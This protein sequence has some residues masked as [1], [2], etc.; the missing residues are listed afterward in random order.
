M[1]S[2]GEDDNVNPPHTSLKKRRVQRAC[3]V[4]RRRKIRCDGNRTPGSRCTTCS[5]NDLECT[6]LEAERTRR[7]SK[8]YVESLESRLDQMERLLSKLCPDGNVSERLLQEASSGDTRTPSDVARSIASVPTAQTLYGAATF[9]SEAETATPEDPV[10][11]D[12]DVDVLDLKLT[13]SVRSMAI[14]PIR[15]RFFGKSSGLKLIQQALD[16]KNEHTG[17]QAENMFDIFYRKRSPF[18]GISPVSTSIPFPLG[19]VAMPSFDRAAFIDVFYNKWQAPSEIKMPSYTFP[20]HDLCCKLIDLYF[21]HTNTIA[22]LLHRPTFERKYADGL[23]LRDSTFGAV[24]L[25]VCAVASTECDD[26]RVLLTGMGTE[27]SAGWKYFQQVQTMSQVFL[28]APCLEDMQMCCLS[29]TFLQGTWA[30]QACWTIVGIGIRLAQDVGAHRRKVYNRKPTVEDELWKR[31]FWIMVILDRGLSTGLGRPC[32]M[33]DTDFDLD[34]PIVCDDEYWEH[35][36]PEQAFKQPPGNPSY[37]AYFVSAIKLSQVLAFALRTIYSINKSKVRFGF[38]GH[39]WEQHIVAELDSALNK[40]IDTVP[41]HL[42]WSP[43]IQKP[44]FLLQSCTLYTSY[45][46]TQILIH[47]PFIPSPR[48]PSPLSYPS[49]AIC[50]NAARLCSHVIDEYVQRMGTDMTPLPV[51][52]QTAAIMAGIILLVSIWGNKKSGLAVN[53]EKDMADVHKCMDAIKLGES[54]YPF[55]GRFWDLLYELASVGDLPLPQSKPARAGKREREDGGSSAASVPHAGQPETGPRIIAGSSR[56]AA[57][58]NQA[59]PT[60][61]PHM[62]AQPQQSPQLPMP[63][64]TG[65][66]MAT[67]FSVPWQPP[68]ALNWGD[69]DPYGTWLGVG[70]GGL[71]PSTLMMDHDGLSPGDAGDS[72]STHA[73]VSGVGASTSANAAPH[74]PYGMDD[75]L[76]HLMQSQQQEQTGA[77]AEAFSTTEFEHMGTGR[78]MP[79]NP[80]SSGNGSSQSQGGAEGLHQTASGIEGMDAGTSAIWSD[81]PGGFEVNDWVLYPGN[82]S[83]DGGTQPPWQHNHGP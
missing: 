54:R 46:H 43:N 39:K 17:D 37:V 38:V 28:T 34:L 65:F 27:Y 8:D 56:A 70:G 36:D 19:L 24:L 64:R 18:T 5:T 52:L 25:M 9:A 69:L 31:A 42:R 1:M 74:V 7:V 26:P 49:L 4:C 21:I 32:A 45:Y 63:G 15:H 66:G 11:S 33:Q 16:I 48:K 77:V 10:S 35:P 57:S 81:A 53:L 82:V 41:D 80:D 51:G 12:E 68:Q 14:N 50:T 72:S 13:E 71:D 40:W 67:S 83:Y 79:L 76:F 29:A 58:F 75:F 47:R 2:S 61:Y 3:D 22:P 55:V 20:E 59:S 78:M 30:P 44:I 73:E 60:S 23:H 6:Y 62:R